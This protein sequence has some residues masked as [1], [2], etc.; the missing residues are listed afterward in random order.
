MIE[1]VKAKLQPYSVIVEETE[2]AIF[3]RPQRYL[4]PDDFTGAMDAIRF[5]K[6]RYV[7]K[8]KSKTGSPYWIISKQPK[9]STNL[10]AKQQLK[11]IIKQLI[12]VE[13]KL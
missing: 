11:Q 5:F 10:D 13:A 6:G 2:T 8:S 9:P 1:D 3:V 12:D 4:T 7:P